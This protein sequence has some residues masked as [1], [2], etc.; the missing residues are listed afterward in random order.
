MAVDMLIACVVM[1]ASADADSTVPPR[2]GRL[3]G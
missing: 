2:M 3:D 1:L